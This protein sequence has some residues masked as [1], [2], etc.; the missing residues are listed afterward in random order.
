MT[1]ERSPLMFQQDAEGARIVSDVQLYL[2]LSAWPQR[3]RN[4]LNTSAPN[5]CVLEAMRLDETWHLKPRHRASYTE[6]HAALCAT[7]RS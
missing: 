1:R 3:G 7:V 6:A 5:Y 2:D 4:K